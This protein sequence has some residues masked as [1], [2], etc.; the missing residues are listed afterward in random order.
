MKINFKDC[1]KAVNQAKYGATAER[2][3]LALK[4]LTELT[5]AIS[6]LEKRLSTYWHVKRQRV[7]RKIV[8]KG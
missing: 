1:Q 4:L 7:D 5:E 6:N 2:K 8:T 3:A